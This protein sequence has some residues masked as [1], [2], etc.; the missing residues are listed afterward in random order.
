MKEVDFVVFFFFL[1]VTVTEILHVPVDAATTLVFTTRQT[2][3]VD[4]F[5]TT[6]EPAGIVSFIRFTMAAWLTER[7]NLIVSSAAVFVAGTVVEVVNCGL[8]VGGR[9]V[10]GALVGGEL[11]GG[12]VVVGADVVGPIFMRMTL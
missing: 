7:T 3:V 8:V 11:T 2:L 6:L 10:A 12:T 4:D 1:S 9:V 5:M